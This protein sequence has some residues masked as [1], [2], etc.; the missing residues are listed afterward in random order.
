MNYANKSAALRGA[1]RAGLV[2]GAFTVALEADGRWHVLN[3]A[4]DTPPVAKPDI[5]EELRAQITLDELKAKLATLQAEAAELKAK[6][7]SFGK[8]ATSSPR[9]PV[10]KGAVGIIW[11]RYLKNEVSKK[12][13]PRKDV[14]AELVAEGFKP[15]TCAAQWHSFKHANAAERKARA[16]A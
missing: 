6:I 15:N 13:R 1:K 3:A 2:E 8:P 9:G 5:Q 11:A 10:T 4:E 14:I 16:A 7:K 12:P